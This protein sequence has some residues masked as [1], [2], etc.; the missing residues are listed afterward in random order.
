MELCWATSGNKAPNA[1]DV[2]IETVQWKYNDSLDDTFSVR[3]CRGDEVLSTKSNITCTWANGG[4]NL[5]QLNNI[6]TNQNDACV[7]N[8]TKLDWDIQDTDIHGSD[9]SGGF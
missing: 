9:T 3:K 7:K 5:R 2:Y 6:L 8:E 4:T 1:S